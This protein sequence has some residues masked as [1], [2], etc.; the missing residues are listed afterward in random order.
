MRSMWRIQAYMRNQ[1]YHLLDLVSKTSYRWN[2]ETDRES[3]LLY[4]GWKLPYT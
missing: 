4:C 3:Y 1:R 2:D